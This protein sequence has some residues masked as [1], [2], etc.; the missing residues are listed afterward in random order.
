MSR[1]ANIL[2]HLE[3][4]GYK[5]EDRVTGFYG[6]VTTI[7]FDL[8]GC[9]QAIV[10]PSADLKDQKPEWFDVTRLEILGDV[11]VMATPDFEKGYVSTGKKGCANK[12]IPQ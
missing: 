8:Y 4:L 5:V 6:V 10:T 1:T 11:P 7:S 9:I 3:L 12:S 2:E